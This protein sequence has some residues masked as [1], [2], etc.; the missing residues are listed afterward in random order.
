MLTN[1]V[2][3]KWIA[4]FA[5]RARMSYRS[6]SSISRAKKAVIT[7]I[8]ASALSATLSTEEKRVGIRQD[9]NAR[10][11]SRL[12]EGW[13]IITDDGSHLSPLSIMSHKKKLKL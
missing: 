10:R 6:D 13:W 3:I 7:P 11:M 8:V 4:K 2:K 5:I 1:L 9:T 12:L